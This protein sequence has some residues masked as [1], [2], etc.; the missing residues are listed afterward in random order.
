MNYSDITINMDLHTMEDLLSSP[1]EWRAVPEI[2][3]LV[4]SEMR[5]QLE[6]ASAQIKSKCDREELYSALD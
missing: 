5:N 6:L 3:F 4:C 2:V 1:T